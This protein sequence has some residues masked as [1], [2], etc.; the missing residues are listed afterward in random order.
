MPLTTSASTDAKIFLR[1]IDR[2][3][4]P[5]K[6]LPTAKP[7]VAA[8]DPATFPVYLVNRLKPEASEWPATP[9]GTDKPTAFSNEALAPLDDLLWV[10]LDDSAYSSIDELI[11][12][13]P[14]MRIGASGPTGEGIATPFYAVHTSTNG[15]HLFWRV[16]EQM[17]TTELELA[18]LGLAYMMGGD[19]AV[20]KGARAMRLP[21]G[22]QRAGG[23]VVTWHEFYYPRPTAGRS[24]GGTKQRPS[25]V[26]PNKVRALGERWLKVCHTPNAESREVKD[27][28]VFNT[29]RT[30]EVMLRRVV[31]TFPACFPGTNTR[32]LY[33]AYV[34]STYT[35]CYEAGV[36]LSI[37]REVLGQFF[38][39]RQN[40]PT[41]T[42][43]KLLRDWDKAKT[44]AAL[45]YKHVYAHCR[46]FLPD[47]M[48]VEGCGT[49]AN[50]VWSYTKPNDT[51]LSL[52]D[53]FGTEV[54]DDL[55][56]AIYGFS[57]DPEVIAFLWLI[58][59]SGSLQGRQTVL[60]DHDYVEHLNLYGAICGAP[61]SGK[62]PLLDALVYRPMTTTPDQPIYKSLEAVK[63]HYGNQ[64]IS[65]QNKLIYTTKLSLQRLVELQGPLG[66]PE[67]HVKLTKDD[68]RQRI[69]TTLIGTMG[70]SEGV[71][72][73]LAVNGL[74]YD[75]KGGRRQ[76]QPLTMICDE[77]MGWLGNIGAYST[78]AGKASSEAAALLGYYNGKG[79]AAL[80]AGR[81]HRLVVP[82]YVKLGIVGC[83]QPS[84]LMELRSRSALAGGGFWAR[85]IVVPAGQILTAAERDSLQGP[86]PVCS[87]Q[88]ALAARLCEIWHESGGCGALEQLK[89]GREV[90][91]G[92]VNVAGGW[93]LTPEAHVYWQEQV[94]DRN[95][96]QFRDQTGEGAEARGKQWGL[97]AR[98]AALLHI[99]SGD[100][101]DGSNVKL[102]RM[103]QAVKLTDWL[104]DSTL[105]LYE[106]CQ[107]DQYDL[108]S[109]RRENCPEGGFASITA[110]RKRYKVC[111]AASG[112]NYMPLPGNLTPRLFGPGAI[113]ARQWE[114]DDSTGK[115]VRQRGYI[116]EPWQDEWD[117]Q[118]YSLIS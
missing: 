16:T 30:D 40:E 69:P 11:Q 62:S 63:L 80:N 118:S 86:R 92:E 51:G 106:S 101:K 107:P 110:I 57:A 60:V 23:H 117:S 47:G 34:W 116:F 75:G 9:D 112:S 48:E 13:F 61:S 74:P 19:P 37:A 45:Y 46:R 81:D 22:H 111:A 67:P 59:V 2:R 44:T 49:V 104:V 32:N 6:Q 108:I 43:E 109:W 94:K 21:D 68:P 24:G 70:T 115:Q 71:A 14:G 103:Q 54:A 114:L 83:I 26:T 113:A 35:A 1:Q 88:P 36:D 53:L 91:P 55:N 72:R 82:D 27:A 41:T 93:G 76:S 15:W 79:R 77:L 95:L 12:A 7:K 98:I 10:D 64:P 78:G 3:T 90:T 87:S 33:N 8:G 105:R 58:A 97:A 25:K 102:L 38:S 20:A 5:I 99:A 42:V 56:A 65:E 100:Y 18:R 17:S 84:K 85:L 89:D 50:G 96:S 66:W 28:A 29:Y 73:H 39:E 31:K 52:E 4:S